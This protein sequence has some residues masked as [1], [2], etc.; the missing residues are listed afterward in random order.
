MISHILLK[1]I[2]K[3]TL[4]KI[5]RESN[6]R[7]LISMFMHI[8]NLQTPTLAQA[9]EKIITYSD[10]RYQVLNA[11]ATFIQSYYRMKKSKEA[12][13]IQQIITKR[14][15]YQNIQSKGKTEI[16]DSDIIHTNNVNNTQRTSIIHTQYKTIETKNNYIQL[17]PQEI[18]I[19]LARRIYIKTIVY[20]FMVAC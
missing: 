17:N 19:Y 18:F 9:M 10:I 15:A 16:E 12:I 13:L 11:Y 20:T 4:D 7:K 5:K 6:R 8:R 14:K 1:N 3:G 2:C